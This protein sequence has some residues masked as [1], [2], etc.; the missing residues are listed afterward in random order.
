MENEKETVA[1]R[2]ERME[3]KVDGAPNSEMM[4]EVAKKLRMEKER[5][6]ELQVRT[7]NACRIKYKITVLSMSS[8]SSPFQMQKSEQRT[9]IQ[10][11][12]QRIQRME[13]QLKDLRQSSAGATPEGLLQKI[14]EETKVNTYIVTQKLPKEIEAKKKAVESLSRLGRQPQISIE[15]Y[16]KTISN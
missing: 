5:E 6:K 12:D 14:E 3:R 16:L 1:K 8:L 15:I 10:H 13:A 4:L 11:A 7:S 2:I 9:A